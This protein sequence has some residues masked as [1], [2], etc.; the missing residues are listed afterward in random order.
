MQCHLS[1]RVWIDVVGAESIW[2]ILME[3]SH[4]LKN[5]SDCENHPESEKIASCDLYLD[6]RNQSVGWCDAEAKSD[7]VVGTKLGTVLEDC[8]N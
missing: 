7:F 8:R 1:S 5:Q 6:N 4:A 3:Q 2:V